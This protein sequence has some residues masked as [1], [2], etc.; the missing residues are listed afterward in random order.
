LGVSVDS[1]SKDILSVTVGGGKDVLDWVNLSQ[2]KSL[3]TFIDIRPILYEQKSS[4]IIIREFG[5]H[6]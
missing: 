6:A 4:F 3:F 2:K 1:I 5:K